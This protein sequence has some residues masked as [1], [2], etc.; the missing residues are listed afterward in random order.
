[1]AD[2]ISI[3]HFGFTKHLLNYAHGNVYL[4]HITHVVDE[5]SHTMSSTCTHTVTL[6]LRIYHCCTAAFTCMLTPHRMTHTL[7]DSQLQMQR[8][9]PKC[10]SSC[11]TWY[12]SCPCEYQFSPKCRDNPDQEPKE[13]PADLLPKVQKMVI[14]DLSSINHRLI[15][16]HGTAV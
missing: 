5:P 13:N 2:H 4:P 3:I 10:D 11:Y 9:C 15:M 16:M 6:M 14:V 7:T 8:E 1:M 12:K